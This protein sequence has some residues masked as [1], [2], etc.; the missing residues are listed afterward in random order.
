MQ[1]LAPLLSSPLRGEE[2]GEGSRGEGVDKGEGVV[3]LIS[4]FRQN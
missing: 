2:I 1:W 3:I 4:P